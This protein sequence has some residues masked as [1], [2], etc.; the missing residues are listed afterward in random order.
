MQW[1][2]F[3]ALGTIATSSLLAVVACDS[4]EERGVLE[5]DAGPEAGPEPNL[6]PA[7][8]PETD[9]GPGPSFDASPEPVVCEVSPC[10]VE[11]AAGANHVCARLST[12]DVSCWGENIFGAIGNGQPEP[13]AGDGK[14]PGKG[15]DPVEGP[16]DV[17]TPARV[18]DVSNVTQISA[19]YRTTCARRADGAVL[20]WGGDEWGQLGLSG[21]AGDSRA[22][23]YRNQVELGAGATRVDVGQRTT[24][25]LL[26]SGELSCWGYND[27]KQ[28]A[29]P[30][31]DIILGPGASDLAGFVVKRA[32]GSDRSSYG[33]TNDGGLLSW[34]ALAAR[35]GSLNPDPTPAPVPALSEVH[36]V[37]AAPTHAC[38][39]AGGSVYCWGSSQ[40]YALCTGLPSTERLPAHAILQTS[41]F[42][43][44]LSVSTNSTCVRLTDG[45]IQCCG[46]ASLGQLAVNPSDAG[47][48]VS[49]AFTRAENFKGH[50]VQVV[51]TDIATCA[52]L[53]NGAVECWG[54]NKHGELGRG[55]RDDD[56]HPMPA[57]VS[58][59]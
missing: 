37:A 11:L 40:T 14:S 4:T 44:Q 46:A 45:T 7:P 38:A 24:C 34:G 22:H 18:T 35:E 57:A 32:A 47:S 59:K 8:S 55:T 2:G 23:P 17:T 52:L 20:C 36:D 29:R 21:S 33:V 1:R 3:V 27:W 30:E 39:I 58:F 28:L 31:E 43:Q 41:A 42:P 15:D 48:S 56:A 12:G 49:M 6:P 19:G 13:D 25:A 10:V 54:G 53:R 51:T 9:G 5:N 50:A 26:A 16:A